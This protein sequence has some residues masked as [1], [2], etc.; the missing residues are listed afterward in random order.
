MLIHPHELLGKL[1]LSLSAGY[2]GFQCLDRSQEGP[3][4]GDYLVGDFCVA[5]VVVHCSSCYLQRECAHYACDVINPIR[6][7]VSTNTA[8]AK[9]SLGMYSFMPIRKARSTNSASP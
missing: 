7:S 6:R 4:L 3:T 8:S 5:R 2:D 1:A 9:A